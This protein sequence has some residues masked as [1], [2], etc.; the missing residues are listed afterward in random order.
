MDFKYGLVR[1]GNHLLID[2]TE[3]GVG[4]WL[5]YVESTI[6]NDPLRVYR[7]IRKMSEADLKYLK[8]FKYP[9]ELLPDSSI[10]KNL[11]WKDVLFGAGNY[12][13]LRMAGSNGNISIPVNFEFFKSKRKKRLLR[14]YLSQ[15]V[16]GIT[17][18]Q[19]INFCKW[20]TKIDSIRA[21]NNYEPHYRYRLPEKEEYVF[22]NK[23][24]DSIPEDCSKSFNYKNSKC[25]L[26]DSM[27]NANLGKQPVSI[28]ELGY[29]ELGIKCIEGNVSEM[30]ATK[31]I[32]MGG[33]YSH[34]ANECQNSSQQL[35]STPEP[36]LG[37]RCIADDKMVDSCGYMKYYYPPNLGLLAGYEGFH[38]NLLELGVGING[39]EHSTYKERGFGGF[40][41]SFK[42]DLLSPYWGIN[43]DLWLG[44][45][46]AAGINY[47]YNAKDNL[48]NH[49]IK[50]FIGFYW[51]GL[52]ITYGYNF[53]A[54]TSISEI[55]T[56]Q[57]TVRY[58]LPV[59][60]WK[61]I[62]PFGNS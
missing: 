5:G 40:T 32:A 2:Q 61:A 25:S 36:W 62:H 18:E 20:R 19:A 4:E 56:H 57:F 54:K 15:P 42:K 33:S 47:N 17:Y 59:I 35:Y 51:N 1:V 22:L 28:F 29:D 43:A 37:F 21:H 55:N 13:L 3:I 38:S 14:A 11:L 50:P 60:K 52:S 34:Y 10:L 12:E 48:A 45:I 30:T 16:T 41:T 7:R 27:S 31:G 24:L 8:S 46:L 23:N 58:Y 44:T 39:E 9:V 26:K 6:D 53:H 49:G